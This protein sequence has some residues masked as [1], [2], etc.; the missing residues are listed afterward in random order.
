MSHERI[1]VPKECNN[2]FRVF[3][4]PSLKSLFQIDFSFFIR[5]TRDHALDD[6]RDFSFVENI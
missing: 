1:L 3:L 4:L 6:D 5:A 2:F